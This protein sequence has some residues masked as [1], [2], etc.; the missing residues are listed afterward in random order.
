MATKIPT[1]LIVRDSEDKTI[2]VPLDRDRITLG[3]SSACEL[4]YP[5]D[6]G[7]SRQH[8]AFVRS[9]DKWQV[10]DLGSKNGTLLNGKRLEQPMPFGL[11][12][13]VVAGHL[14]I[15]F[16]GADATANMARDKVVFVEQPEALAKSTTTVAASLDSLIGPAGIDDMNKTSIIQTNPQMQ[17]LIRA[18]RELAGHRPLRELFEVIMDLA[19]EAVMA[20]RGVLMTLENGE[21]VV[22]AARGAGFKISTTVR[23]RV[24]NEKTSLL[25]RDTQLDQ[26]LREQMSIVQNKVRSMIAVPLQTNDRVIGLIYVDTP[27]LIREFTREDLGLLTV[28]ANV[29]AIRI[30]HARLSEIEAAERAMAKELEQAAHIQMGLL[31]ARS[32]EVPG[33]D[34]A[35][36]TLPCRT[37]GGD[38]YD[39]LP[40]PD[41]RIGVLIGDVAGKGMPASLLMSSLQARVKVLFDDGDELAQKITRLNKNTAASCPDNRFITFFMTVADPA[42]GELVYTNAGHNPPL[43]VRKNGT[44]EQLKGGGII[45]GIVPMAKYQE[46]RIRMDSG[47][48]LVLYSDGVTEAVN[49]ADV[50]YGEDRLGELAASLRGRPAEELVAAIQ[51][52]VAKFSAGAPQADDITVVVMRR[53]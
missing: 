41:G 52:E 36:G 42:T 32:P 35:A 38:Y 43:L 25:V 13:R 28:M 29:A 39:Y 17:A 40:F 14:T 5:D 16:P 30:E 4:S 48:T 7:L 12:D 3:R 53:L 19:M 8:V 45:L 33:M 44:V 49:P 20:A 31:P 51:S 50:D 21:L 2:V 23:D 22:R 15:E 6:S 9:G 37:V 26:A 11:G 47:D 1:E 27:D 24:L 10:Q 18:G 34:I 46:F